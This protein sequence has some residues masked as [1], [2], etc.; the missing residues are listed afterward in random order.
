MAVRTPTVSGSPYGSFVGL[1]SVLALA[2]IVV[3]GLMWLVGIVPWYGT[4]IAIAC[5]PVLTYLTRSSS[6]LMVTT[7]ALTVDSFGRTIF[8]PWDNVAGIKEGRLGATLIFK[9][10]QLV[11]ARTPKWKWAFDGFD[12]SWRTRPTSVAIMRCVEQASI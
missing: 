2:L 12:L 3:V 10:A 5:S 6:I 9:E 4:V 8:V 11:G 7:D 1:L